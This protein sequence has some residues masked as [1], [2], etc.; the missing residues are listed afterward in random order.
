MAVFCSA[1]CSLCSPPAGG[2][3]VGLCLP[4]GPHPLSGLCEFCRA[5]TLPGTLLAPYGGDAAGEG[6]YQHLAH[7]AVLEH[8]PHV[9]RARCWKVCLKVGIKSL[10]LW[11][12]AFLSWWRESMPPQKAGDTPLDMHQ[13][14]MLYSTCKVPGVTKDKIHNYF[15]TG[16]THNSSWPVAH[17]QRTCLCETCVCCAV[18]QRVKVLAPPTWWSCAV[19]GSSSSM[20]SATEK[21]SPHQKSSGT[22]DRY[23]RWLCQVVCKCGGS[24]HLKVSLKAGRS[25]PVV[26][27]HQRTVDFYSWALKGSRMQTEPWKQIHAQK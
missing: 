21:S 27:K 14:R 3:V 1:D 24:V 22:S 23:F 20:H 4:G 18:T 16:R 6:Q 7:A 25:D 13:F 17:I 11:F 12:G 9:S 19:D 8:D 5:G 26:H 15:K 2:L 10:I